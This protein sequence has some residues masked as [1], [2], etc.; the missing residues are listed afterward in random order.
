MFQSEKR[1]ET[2][3]PIKDKTCVTFESLKARMIPTFYSMDLVSNEI[4]AGDG[5]GIEK[6]LIIGSVYFPHDEESLMAPKAVTRLIKY[7]QEVQLVLILG[8][9]ANAYHVIWRAQTLTK[10]KKDC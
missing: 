5:N 8:Y 2:C 7:N 1:G 3:L 10:E 4:K 6:R 9:D